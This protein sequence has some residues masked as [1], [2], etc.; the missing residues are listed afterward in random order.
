MRYEEPEE[1]EGAEQNGALSKMPKWFSSAVLL[2][3]VFG[4][5]L[6][7]YY[8]Y[9]NGGK[10]VKEEDL[11]VVEADKTPIKEKP[12]DA[13]GM[14]F[15][16]QDKTIYETF[17]NNPAPLAKVERVLPAPEEPMTSDEE[18]SVS[19]VAPEKPTEVAEVP[20]A[21]KA[22]SVVKEESKPVPVIAAPKPTAVEKPTVS[23][24]KGVTIQLGAYPSDAE[25]K[26]DWARIKAK[27]STLSSKSPQIVKASVGGKEFYRLRVGGFADEKAAKALCAT[28]SAQ[29]QGC[30][31]PK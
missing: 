8:S 28:L 24:K 7:A 6:L 23:S 4:F 27:F 14:Q 13:G 12:T 31:L 15:P 9:Q 19:A 29:K 20:V 10:P 26:K 18:N 2:G 3:S 1:I 30:I 16:N 21:E 5:I 25:A 17:S 22:V 11:L